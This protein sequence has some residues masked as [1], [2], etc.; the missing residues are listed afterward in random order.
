M[1][2]GVCEGGSEEYFCFD[3]F[4]GARVCGVFDWDNKLHDVAAGPDQEEWVGYG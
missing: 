2:E 1:G 4:G 3:I